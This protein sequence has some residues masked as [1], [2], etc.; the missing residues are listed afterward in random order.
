MS[1]SGEP[2]FMPSR[3]NA[4]RPLDSSP[5]DRLSTDSP[6]KESRE[7][8]SPFI[9]APYVNVAR[10]SRDGARVDRLRKGPIRRTAVEGTCAGMRAGAA[11]RGLESAWVRP[12]IVVEVASP[13]PVPSVPVRVRSQERA[14]TSR[15]KLERGTDES[16][17]TPPVAEP[18]TF[19]RRAEAKRSR[20]SPKLF[21]RK[22]ATR[23]EGV[24]DRGVRGGAR[25]RTGARDE[26]ARLPRPRATEARTAS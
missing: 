16:A 10:R 6:Q 18:R 8:C 2:G 15:W 19:S 24:G 1:G 25:A 17:K 20:P 9:P 21:S 22:I 11:R 4:R 5:P 23:G 7:R 12:R 14:R 26:N 13:P 3:G